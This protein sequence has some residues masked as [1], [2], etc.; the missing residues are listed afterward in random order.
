MEHP[1]ATVIRRYVAALLA[2]DAAAAMAC[3]A[4][5]MVLHVGGRSR[6]AG[7]YAG[8][9]AY[10]DFVTRVHQDTDGAV[11]ILDVHDILG[12]DHHAVL[13][14]KERFSRG[15]QVVETDR[16]VVYELRDERIVEIWNYDSDQYA[17]D[18]LFPA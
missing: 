16:V 18:E 2:G 14:V 9:E 8:V 6:H 13:L 10:L 4:D 5:D 3:Y 7:T 11:E 15:D 17:Y 12:S 1:N